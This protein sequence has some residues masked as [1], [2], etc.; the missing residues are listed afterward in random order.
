MDPG[1]SGSAVSGGGGCP[2]QSLAIVQGA[3]V[4]QVE[5]E[6]QQQRAIL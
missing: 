5:G 3:I 6:L 1:N 4:D 2:H